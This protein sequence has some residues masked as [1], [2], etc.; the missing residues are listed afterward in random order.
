MT[1]TAHVPAIVALSDHVVPVRFQQV[2]DKAMCVSHA[3]SCRAREAW[4]QSSVYWRYNIKKLSSYIK[5]CSSEKINLLQIKQFSINKDGDQDKSQI[6]NDKF[7]K[8][9]QFFFVSNASSD[10]SRSLH[11]L[12]HDAPLLDFY[13][14]YLVAGTS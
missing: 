2:V 11:S 1:K 7:E 8:N 5:L 3:I 14:F 9:D 12:E 4:T 13:R 10:M 6:A